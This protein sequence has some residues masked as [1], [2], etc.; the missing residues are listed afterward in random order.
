MRETFAKVEKHV[1]FGKENL[2]CLILKNMIL[3][4]ITYV[5]SLDKNQVSKDVYV[6][7]N[8]CV[9]TMLLNVKVGSMQRP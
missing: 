7:R 8:K 2:F 5:E 4:H 9:L 6:D 3:Q 1:I